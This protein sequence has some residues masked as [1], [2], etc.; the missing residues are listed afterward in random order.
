MKRIGGQAGCVNFRFIQFQNGVSSSVLVIHQHPNSRTKSSGRQSDLIPAVY[1]VF[2]GGA[3]KLFNQFVSENAAVGQ[4]A[5]F[6]DGFD[7]DSVGAKFADI[8]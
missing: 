2:P 5:I 3:K 8:G 6:L 7:G 4:R 1:G